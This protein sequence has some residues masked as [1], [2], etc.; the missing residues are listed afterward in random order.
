MQLCR[1]GW[2]DIL[3]ESEIFWEFKLWSQAQQALLVKFKEPQHFMKMKD[4]D[5]VM[6][7]PTSLR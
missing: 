4:P 6:N 3:G 1:L 2:S 5:M 7:S